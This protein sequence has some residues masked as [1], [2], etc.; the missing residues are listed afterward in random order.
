QSFYLVSYKN[1][2]VNI[3]NTPTSCIN[4]YRFLLFQL[5]SLRKIV[6]ITKI[7]TLMYYK[8][9]RPYE[10]KILFRCHH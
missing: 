4:I 10:I 2:V 6:T 7:I 1:P 8:H 9:F 5:P 3:T